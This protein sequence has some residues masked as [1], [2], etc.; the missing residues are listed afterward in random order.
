MKNII[1]AGFDRHLMGLFVTAERLG[2]TIPDLFLN[3]DFE[4]MKHFILSTSTLSSSAIA[5][6][7][8]GPVVQ[9]GFG[10]GYTVTGAKIGAAISSFKVNFVLIFL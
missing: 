7:G 1:G 9:D 3:N 6:G 4:Y 8:F 5:L 10:I 2:K